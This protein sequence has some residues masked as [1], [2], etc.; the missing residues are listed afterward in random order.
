M[1]PLDISFNFPK[2]M[3]APLV[4][5]NLQSDTLIAEIYMHGLPPPDENETKHNFYG[6]L[7]GIIFVLAAEIV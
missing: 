2:T 7:V 4:Y 6:K 5:S 3:E 1:T